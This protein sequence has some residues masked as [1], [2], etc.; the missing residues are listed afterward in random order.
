MHSSVPTREDPTAERFLLQFTSQ[1][2]L[3]LFVFFVYFLDR[4]EMSSILSEIKE[5]RL[6]FKTG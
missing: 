5:E 1:I 2:I 4:K 6:Q 3:Y